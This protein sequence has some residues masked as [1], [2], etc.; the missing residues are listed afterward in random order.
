MGSK[1]SPNRSDNKLYYGFSYPAKKMAGEF[2]KD[3]VVHNEDE[4]EQLLAMYDEIYYEDYKIVMKYY[5]F[6]ISH[7]DE[8]QHYEVS[9]MNIGN[10]KNTMDTIQKRQNRFDTHQNY[11]EVVSMIINSFTQGKD[12]MTFLKEIK[13]QGGKITLQLD[14]NKRYRFCAYNKQFMIPPSVSNA[15][16]LDLIGDAGM[17][18][19]CGMLD[20]RVFDFPY[21]K[22]RFAF[23]K[24]LLSEMFVT[25]DLAAEAIASRTDKLYTCDLKIDRVALI[26]EG[27]KIIKIIEIGTEITPEWREKTQ[28][29]IAL[30]G[31]YTKPEFA[32]VA[33]YIIT[34]EAGS[35]L[36][37]HYLTAEEPNKVIPDQIPYYLKP[38]PTITKKE[39]A[40]LRE[41]CRN[42]EQ[43]REN[44]SYK[45]YF[46]KD[47]NGKL[48]GYGGNCSACGFESR[49]INSF[50]LKNFEVEVLTEDSE[51]LFKFCLYLCANDAAAAGGWLITDVSIGGMSPDKWLSEIVKAEYILPEFLF[52]R[53]S[54]RTQITYDILGGDSKANGEVM[55]DTDRRELNLTLTPLMAAKWVT[56]NIG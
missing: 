20:G 46:A 3:N 30:R 32:D 5:Q 34:G 51:Q 23:D 11:N 52:C 9:K 44:R 24:N 45:N 38:M 7:G 42:I 49:V 1:A 28:K 4:L 53:I 21:S 6:Y 25:D 48:F 47:I 50:D 39:F 10:L 37:A 27:D 33:E 56:D 17:L 18:I 40:Y 35:R 12:T 31:D 15:E 55:F 36:S 43:Y 13:D 14:I 54:Y 8:Q 41:Q 16:M 19:K 29:Y 22:S 26:G 2:L